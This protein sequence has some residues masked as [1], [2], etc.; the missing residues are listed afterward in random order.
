MNFLEQIIIEV[1]AK[2]QASNDRRR[3][4]SKTIE[5]QQKRKIKK[6]LR[7]IVFNFAFFFIFLN[8]I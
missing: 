6:N 5:K 3:N 2:Q 1:L 4:F 8:V 7:E